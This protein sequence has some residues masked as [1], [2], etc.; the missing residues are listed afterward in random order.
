MIPDVEKGDQILMTYVPGKGTVVSAKGTEKGVVEGKDFSDALFSV[1][2][3]ANP[4]QTDLKKAL[5]GG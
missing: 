1:W 4:V 5:L 3:G 2:L